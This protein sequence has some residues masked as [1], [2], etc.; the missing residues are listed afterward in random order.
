MVHTGQGIGAGARMKG[1][2]EDGEQTARGKR[3]GGRY[4][5]TVDISTGTFYNRRFN[6]VR[7]RFVST[8]PLDLQKSD[9][10]SP[11]LAVIALTASLTPEMDPIK[12]VTNAYGRARGN[13]F[14]FLSLCLVDAT[15]LQ[16][17]IALSFHFT[18]FNLA[19]LYFV[20]IYDQLRD[21]MH[22]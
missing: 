16:R 9:I 18:R 22:N 3:W 6:Y 12:I 7:R 1:R 10:K 17:D 20:A 21:K 13:R 19:L 4:L 11:L 15:A 5:N 2:R 8:R 14:R